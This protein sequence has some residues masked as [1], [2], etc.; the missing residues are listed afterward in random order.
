MAMIRSHHWRDH[1]K[2]ILFSLCVCASFQG[3][4]ALLHCD[5]EVNGE[6]HHHV[7]APTTDPYAAQSVDIG[8]RFR[9]K[10]VVL[11]QGDSIEL[12]NVYVYYQTRR[13]P[14]VMQHAKYLQPLALENPRPG[15]LTGRVALYS[16]VLGKELAYQCALHK[17][18]P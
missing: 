13:Q 10:A 17:E 11:G 16:P 12:V 1:F 9:V 4:A 7:F 3:Q 2:S 15:A 6:V 18:F 14:M 8:E 5:F